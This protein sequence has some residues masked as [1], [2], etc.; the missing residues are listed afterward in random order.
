MQDGVWYCG[1]T[2]SSDARFYK[3]LVLL[4]DALA[5]EAVEESNA[6]EKSGLNV[7]LQTVD[8]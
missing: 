7:F 3:K 6:S 8:Q 2:Y 1:N 4:A 5:S